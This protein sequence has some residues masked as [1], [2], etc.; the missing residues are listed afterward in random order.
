MS[1][2]PG[3]CPEMDEGPKQTPRSHGKTLPVQRAAVLQ[4]AGWAGSANDAWKAVDKKY[5]HTFDTA[6]KRPGQPYLP[7]ALSTQ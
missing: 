4:N 1:N 5:R 2:R 3:R 6:I 7:A